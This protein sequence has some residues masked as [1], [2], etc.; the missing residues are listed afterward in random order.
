MKVTL[1]LRLR[2]QAL[3][4]KSRHFSRAHCKHRLATDLLI[5]RLEGLCILKHDIKRIL[6]L[7]QAEVIAARKSL[8][9]RTESLGQFIELTVKRA[10][11]KLIGQPLRSLPVAHLDKRIIK[12]L[13]RNALASQLPR[14][15]LMLVKINL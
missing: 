2:T 1:H 5:D 13:E 12:H 6:H 3:A 4:Q 11:T 8:R 15:P 9:H 7:H 10:K 14:Q